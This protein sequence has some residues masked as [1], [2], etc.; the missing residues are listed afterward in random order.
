MA[1]KSKI[2][3]TDAT[4]NPIRGCSRVSEGCR[5]C[6]AERTAARF[7]GSGQPYQGLAELIS[8]VWPVEMYVNMVHGE[9]KG[10]PPIGKVVA[11]PRWTG[12]VRFIPEMLDQPLRWKR[13]RKIFV[14]SMSDL[15]HEKVDVRWVD[16]IVA[17][18]LVTPQH[19]YQVLTKR[20]ERMR[21]YLCNVGARQIEPHMQRLRAGIG[22]LDWPWRNIQW[23]VS[24]EDQK[25]ADERIPLLLQTPTAVRWVSYEPA[26]GPVDFTRS[27]PCG[28]YC[29]ESVGHVDH[30]PNGN[31]GAIDWIVAGGESGPGARQAHPEWFR[32][33][34]DQCKTA[35]VPFFFKQWGEWLH[36]SQMNHAFSDPELDRLTFK[37]VCR[38][39]GKGD[40]F[41]RVGKKRAGHLLDGKVHQ[42]FPS[43][44]HESRITSHET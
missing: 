1:D 27:I 40:L 3:W 38:D 43:T 28:Y 14:N 20:P 29:D 10:D 34:R 2:E 4:W 13:P 5:H 37:T 24:V 44:S 22:R 35:G 21:N 31:L 9:L 25:T 42:Q 12:D 33:A 15:F 7:S 30:G 6:Y 11:E 32:I 16:Q 41:F 36:A 19:T 8:V 18:M 39:T 23:G 26:L 17:A